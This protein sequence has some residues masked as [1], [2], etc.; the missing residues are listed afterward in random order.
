MRA[1]TSLTVLSPSL[2][3]KRQGEPRTLGVGGWRTH[4]LHQLEEEP[5]QRQEEGDQ[6]VCSGVEEGQVADQRL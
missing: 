2:R 1:S 3:S 6:E 4:H 5:G